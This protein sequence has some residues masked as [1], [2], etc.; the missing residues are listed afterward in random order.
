MHKDRLSASSHSAVTVRAHLH[1]NNNL[2]A[3]AYNLPADARYLLGVSYPISERQHILT[4]KTLSLTC[5]LHQLSKPAIRLIGSSHK[6]LA[7][8]EHIMGLARAPDHLLGLLLP[9]QGHQPMQAC[10][11]M[12]PF[13][14][15]NW[16]ALGLGVD[17]FGAALG[18][19]DPRHDQN[20]IGD[21]VGPH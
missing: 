17:V 21:E 11:G 9:L 18:Y 20:L 13:L 1:N 12:N 2:P 14:G 5:M 10:T 7:A 8:P 4:M 19:G 3:D 16:D 6:D 15:H